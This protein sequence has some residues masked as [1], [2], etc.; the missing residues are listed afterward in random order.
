MTDDKLSWRAR[1][2][3]ELKKALWKKS[4]LSVFVLVTLWNLSI[5]SDFT[6]R[7][8]EG[9]GPIRET[10]REI[11]DVNLHIQMRLYH[12]LTFAK[13][14]RLKAD[15]IRLLYIDDAAHWNYLGGDI[16]TPRSFLADIVRAAIKPPNQVRAI[17][18]DIDLLAARGHEDGSDFD[19]HVPG[20][21]ALR[22]AIAE[23]AKAGIPVI[24]NSA[25]YKEAGQ[26]VMLPNIIKASEIPSA[27]GTGCGSDRCPSFGY[28]NLPTDKRRIP[29]VEDA[30]VPG[31]KTPVR[32][33]SFA[34]ALAAN[35]KDF[36]RLQKELHLDDPEPAEMLGTFM[37]EDSFKSGLALNLLTP[38][39]DEAA[40]CKGKILL[41]GGHWH[42]A[43]GHGQNL[44]D[45]HLSPAGVISGLGIH[46]TYLASILQ[47]LYTK[48]VP[49]WVGIVFDVLVGI[50]IFLGFEFYEGRWKIAFLVVAFPV[51]IVAAYFALANANRYL[52]FLFPVELYFL[53]VAYEMIE[54]HIA[55][56]FKGKNSGKTEDAS[57]PLLPANGD[58]K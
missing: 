19:P 11:R 22:S 47:P 44:V 35:L 15:D 17:G 58:T 21:N 26:N 10:V 9:K 18:I 37:P 4:A 5:A 34:L 49:F 27:G 32:Q 57:P 16:P 13:T 7:L 42:D 12:L 53:H 24:L 23:A 52:D 54:P 39:T 50:A 51:P 8:L 46:A 29:L 41:V 20:N 48:E 38:G 43:Q 25:F 2:W 30:I 55:K 14:D 6:T 45:S 3:E 28:V 1:L 36:D 56:F 31:S 40:N 33:Y